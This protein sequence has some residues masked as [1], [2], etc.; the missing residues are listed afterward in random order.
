MAAGHPSLASVPSAG[1]NK[2]WFN[3]LSYH[4]DV[5]LGEQNFT[6]DN[7]L[8]GHYSNNIADWDELEL[9]AG[10]NIVV[11]QS[12]SNGGGNPHD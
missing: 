8:C 1:V 5:Q 11:P 9:L 4:P 12:P 10:G 2:F 3:M 6:L 7:G